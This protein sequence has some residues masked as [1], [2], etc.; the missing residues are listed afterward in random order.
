[1]IWIITVEVIVIAGGA[2]WTTRRLK[3][4]KQRSYL[5][6][7]IQGVLESVGSLRDEKRPPDAQCCAELAALHAPGKLCGR[8]AVGR[9]PQ[10]GTIRRFAWMDEDDPCYTRRTKSRSIPCVHHLGFI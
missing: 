6:R 4:F 8:T 7:E 9:C 10:A 3:V 1:M 2:L 5:E